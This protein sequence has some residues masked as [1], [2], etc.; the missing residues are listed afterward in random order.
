MGLGS[1]LR[2]SE[3]WA[4]G[5]GV[6]ERTMGGAEAVWALAPTPAP[7]DWV[8]RKS[9]L[10]RSSPGVVAVACVVA[11]GRPVRSRSSSRACCA[12]WVWC[13]EEVLALGERA[14]RPDGGGIDAPLAA[15]TATDPVRPDALD[16]AE[17]RR[18]RRGEGQ[19]RSCIVGRSSTPRE[20]VEEG[21]VCVV[22]QR[23]R[24]DPRPTNV[25]AATR[26][27]CRSAEEE[28]RRLASGRNEMLSERARDEGCP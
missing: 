28:I 4:Y 3:W 12:L 10:L 5:G 7:S 2:S 18:S 20:V 24:G 9:L 16:V 14:P 1:G 19:L 23:F 21:C 17:P 27:N 8:A 26:C 22:A 6:A 13:E 25:F 11:R 15:S